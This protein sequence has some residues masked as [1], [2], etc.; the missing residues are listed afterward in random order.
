MRFKRV[1]AAQ[2]AVYRRILAWG[3]P[4]VAVIAVAMPFVHIGALA[5]VPLLVAVHLVCVRVV[6][7][8]DTQR[9]LRPV[10]RL[11]NRWLARFS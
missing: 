9:L 8:R 7:V 11:L 2:A 3:V 1:E 10:R 5:V 4:I 6:M